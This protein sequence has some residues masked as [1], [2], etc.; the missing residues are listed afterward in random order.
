MS[1]NRSGSRRVARTLAVLVLAASSALL[2]VQMVSPA[3]AAD[4]CQYTPEGCPKVTPNLNVVALE[5]QLGSPLTAEATLENGNYP[6]GTLTFA[7]F[8]PA[9][10]ACEQT[11]FRSTVTVSSQRTYSSAEGQ[12]DGWPFPTVVGS[13]RWTVSYSGDAFNN[14]VATACGAVTASVGKAVASLSVFSVTQQPTVGDAL[15]AGVTLSGFQP[16]GVISVSLH[17]PSDP[18]CQAPPV[19]TGEL[20]LGGVGTGG[21]FAS[22]ADPQSGSRNA[23]AYGTWNW[24]ATYPGDDQNHPA[25]VGCG[26]ASSLVR[27]RTTLEVTANPAAA[28]YGETLE[29]EALLT[30]AVSATGNLV[31]LRLYAPSA[32]S[33]LLESPVYRAYF[34]TGPDGRV[35]TTSDPIIAVGSRVASQPG[36]WRWRAMYGESAEAYGADTG[37]GSAPVEVDRY[38]TGLDTEITPAVVR[39]GQISTISVTLTRF[40]TQNPGDLRVS[41]HPP[42]GGCTGVPTMQDSWRP[43][44]QSVSTRSVVPTAGTWY[45]RVVY[46]GDA[47]NAPASTCV[48]FDVLRA[49]SQ[50]DPSASPPNATIGGTL[51]LTGL[52]TSQAATSG[53]VTVRLFAPTDSSCAAAVYSEVVPV[54]PASDF[55]TTVG[56][57][58]PRRI[59]RASPIGLW[60]WTAS[61][62]GDANNLPSVSVCGA[63]GVSVTRR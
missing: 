6:T 34:A 51:H 52:V 46:D 61:Y 20:V 50:V 2:A 18:L 26:Q 23:D 38:P 33:C 28:A 8:A 31:Q 55:R 58:V 11:L 1:A 49:E 29:A 36:V 16:L 14:G 5:G 10:Q 59:N 15:D 53:F 44:G 17:H 7:A 12:L 48:P 22:L 56:F 43:F 35:S 47:S 54:G 27:R 41:L 60:N 42:S 24:T 19:F 40:F 39:A 62:S 32:G 13:Y 25:V 57:V 45:W 63:A 21:L 37:C 4:D 3:R 9:D 30:N